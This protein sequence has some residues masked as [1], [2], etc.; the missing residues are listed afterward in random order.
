ML[1]CLI[2]KCFD[3][4]NKYLG[5]KNFK[6]ARNFKNKFFL[7]IRISDMTPSRGRNEK[8]DGKINRKW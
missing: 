3:F 1:D 2:C 8:K 5:K 4:I 7:F 6:F